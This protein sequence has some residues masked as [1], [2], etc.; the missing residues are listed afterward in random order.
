[1]TRQTNM[2]VLLSLFVGLTLIS[3][4]GAGATVVAQEAKQKA[5]DAARKIDEY[6]MLG[7]CDYGARLDNF[8]VDLMKEPDAEGYVICYGAAG[9]DSGTGNYMLQVT[10]D[11]LVN[12]RGVDP[13]RIKTIYG[14]RYKD[15]IGTAT[16]LW[17]VPPG[18]PAPE[19]ASYSNKAATF[20]GKFAEYEGWDD[21]SVISEGESLGAGEVTFAALADVL[22]QQPKTRA[23]IVAFAER[24]GTP[25]AWR[26]VAKSTVERL[27][28]SQGIKGDRIKIIYGGR[29]QVKVEDRRQSTIQLWVLPEDAPP[30][31]VEAKEPE[32][33]PTK[34]VQLGSFNKYRLKD[35]KDARH[36]FEGFADVL[37]ADE[38]SRAFIIIRPDVPHLDVPDS[39]LLLD[40]DEPPDVD[41][42]QLVEKWKADL[43]KEYG[44]NHSRVIVTV[45]AAQQEWDAGAL[46]MWIVPPGAELPDPY[47][48]EEE[49]QSLAR[50]ETIQ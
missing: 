14:G 48:V 29:G 17:I 33:A 22:R 24:G 37:K 45:A 27:Q 47:A 16:E 8:V 40:V 21:F 1:M 4:S 9:D 23:Y 12:M 2:K 41:M 11:Y 46:E 10:K 3:L 20:N 30:P 7:G 50:E 39:E 43:A 26:R 38:Q 13:A 25:G 32:G 19:P 36:I 42:L 18:A 35:A 28:D 5:G 31:V 44:V 6:G 34:P 15:L 49:D